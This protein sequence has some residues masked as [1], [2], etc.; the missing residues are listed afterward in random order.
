[1]GYRKKHWFCSLLA[2]LCL[3]SALPRMES[4]A[5]VAVNTDESCTLSIT[6]TLNEPA[7]DWEDLKKSEVMV[8]VCRIASM[9]ASGAYKMLT[10]FES[11][12]DE[13]E[14]L[15]TDSSKV[16][17]EF[18][19]TRAEEAAEIFEKLPSKD[20]KDCAV[21]T[22]K[23][24][25]GKVENLSVG[26]YLVCPREVKTDHYG[27]TFEP[28]LVSLP[29]NHYGTVSGDSSAPSQD[30]SWDYHMQVGLKPEQQIR[31]GD[32]IIEKTLEK[33]NA[34][35]GPAVFVFRV[36]GVRDLDGDGTKETVYSNVH[37]LSFTKAGTDVIRIENL[38]AGTEVTVEEIYAGSAYETVGS[39]EQSNLVIKASEDNPDAQPEDG[40][41]TESPA[42]AAFSNRYNDSLIPGTGI[43]NH[44]TYEKAAGDAG[45]TGETGT[46][47]LAG[48]WK[49]EQILHGQADNGPIEEEG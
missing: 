34:A 3:L 42:T 6:M 46:T 13:L 16:N 35:L 29:G 45:N 17:V 20:G 27:Y 7:G 36:E 11:L 21:V 32:L 49:W 41:Q 38:P 5:R 44:F 37:T 22:V 40:A 47:G 43:T 4:L 39:K 48:T 1:M 12:K 23:D 18:W 2:A 31:Y 19:K 8:D 15:N 30:D 9:D 28:Y 24:G 14:N 26:L 25:S 10:G 33:H